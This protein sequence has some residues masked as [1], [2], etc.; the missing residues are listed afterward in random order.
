VGQVTTAVVPLPPD[1]VGRF[2]ADGYLV[3]RGA[4]DPAPLAAE[5]DRALVE[6]HRGGPDTAVEGLRF[7]YVPMMGE[8]SPVSLALLDALAE[9]AAQLLG[10]PVLPLRAKGTRY[11]ADTDPHRDATSALPSLGFLCYLEPLVAATG[12]LQVAPGSHL[13]VTAPIEVADLVALETEPGDL[14]GLDEHL[15][16]ASR[17]G[18]AR[19]Q[20]RVDFFAAPTDADTAALARQY[21]AATFPPDWDGGY[22][23]AAYPSYGPFWRDRPRPWHADLEAVGAY[24]AAAAQEAAYPPARP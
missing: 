19:R 12:A 1:A 14:I 9:P 4:V 5:L 17:G 23:P 11:A 6:G 10:G 16:H 2:E 22:D 24:A 3:L 15:V 20:W 18:A 13:D 7:R 21:V 8:R